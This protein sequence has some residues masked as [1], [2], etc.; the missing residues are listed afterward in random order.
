M[1]VSIQIQKTEQGN[2]LVTLSATENH[3]LSCKT[4]YVLYNSKSLILLHF[5]IK[6]YGHGKGLGNPQLTKLDIFL[7][8][9]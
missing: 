9:T 7:A 2:L 4:F 6:K 1:F 3:I 5:L 8:V